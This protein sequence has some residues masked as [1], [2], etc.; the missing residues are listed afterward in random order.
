M[1]QGKG[2]LPERRCGRVWTEIGKMTRV[3]ERGDIR[4]WAKSQWATLP[5]SLVLSR[6]YGGCLPLVDIVNGM[7]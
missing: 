4:I 5:L 2:E 1:G 3:V 7:V 6:G